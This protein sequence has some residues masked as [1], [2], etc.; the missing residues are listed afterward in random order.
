M[1]MMK[2]L[3]V[4]GWGLVVSSLWFLLSWM[5]LGLF[6]MWAVLMPGVDYGGGSGDASEG[7]V[8]SLVVGII[9]L[10][11]GLYVLLLYRFKRP[12]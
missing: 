4:L 10:G 7:L 8:Q 1:M 2:W 3:L 5:I 6:I 9:L 12:G 11:S